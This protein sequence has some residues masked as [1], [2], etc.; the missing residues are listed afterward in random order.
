[1]L[2]IH[3]RWSWRYAWPVAVVSVGLWAMVLAGVR[4]LL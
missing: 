4:V 1:M 3:Q 2:T